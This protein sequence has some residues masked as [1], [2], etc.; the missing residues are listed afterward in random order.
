MELLEH[1]ADD[2]WH[3]PL[4]WHTDEYTWIIRRPG[5]LSLLR[6]AGSHAGRPSATPR[7]RRRENDG[8]PSRHRACP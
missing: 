6:L 2:G 4:L 8:L 1:R 5:A 3:E 7:R